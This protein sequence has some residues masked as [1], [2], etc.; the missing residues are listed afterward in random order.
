M[1]TARLNLYFY[2]IFNRPRM[3]L[4]FLVASLLVNT[5]CTK[6]KIVYICLSRTSHRYHNSPNCSGLSRCSHQ[7]VK[8][9]IDE[10][11]KNGRTACQLEK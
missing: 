5:H 9:T 1:Q 10:A 6:P 3:K 11:K 7:I 4:I 8:M 2:K